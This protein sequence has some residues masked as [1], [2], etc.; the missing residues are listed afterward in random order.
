MDQKSDDEILKQVTEIVAAY[1]S[2][3]EVAAA[4]AGE[5]IGNAGLYHLPGRRAKA[6]NA[7]TL[8]ARPLW[9]DP[10]RLS[11]QMEFARRLSYDRAQLCRQAQRFRQADRAGQAGEKE[12][13]RL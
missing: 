8:S 1:V 4:D 13:L 7:E 5:K 10:R 11:R 3:N 9:H 12:T 6:K 2:K